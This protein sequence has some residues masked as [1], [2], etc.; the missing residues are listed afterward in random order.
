MC[1][2]VA[3]YTVRS[4]CEIRPAPAYKTCLLIW[5]ALYLSLQNRRQMHCVSRLSSFDH[6]HLIFL[7][8]NKATVLHQA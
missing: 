3:L 5:S 8:G 7:T 6:S 1:A 4:L 2:I